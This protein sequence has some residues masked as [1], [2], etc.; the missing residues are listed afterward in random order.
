MPTFKSLISQSRKYI[1]NGEKQ[2]NMGIDYNIRAKVD[3]FE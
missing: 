3:N 1:K 2:K